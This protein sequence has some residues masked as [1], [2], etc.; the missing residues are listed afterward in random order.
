MTT[1]NSPVLSLDALIAHLREAVDRG[2]RVRAEELQR[3]ILQHLA[4]ESTHLEDVERAVRGLMSTFD[5]AAIEFAPVQTL[6]STRTRTLSLD[7]ELGGDAEASVFPVWFGTDR[8]PKLNGQGFTGERNRSLTCGRADVYIPK[9]HRPGEIGSSLLT[10]LFRLDLRDDSLRIQRIIGQTT[11]DFF[12]EISQVMRETRAAGTAAH[13]LFYLHGFNVGFDDAAI[14]A[15][16]L[17]KDLAV[18]GAT[19]F[20]SWPSKDSMFQ[21]TADEATIEAS[22]PAI[23]AFLVDFA[24]RC[25]ADKIHIIAHSMGNRG[26]LRALQ[27]IATNA[28]LRAKVR[29]GQIILAAPD[30]DQDVFADLAA[31]CQRQSEQT[32]LYASHQDLAVH[33]SYWKHAAPRAGYFLPYTLVGDIETVAVPDLDID[34][35]GHSYYA[36]AK[37]LLDDM[38]ERMLPSGKSREQRRLSALMFEGKRLWSLQAAD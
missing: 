31:M 10:R 21:Y 8:K 5:R 36:Q 14:R 26:L 17:G 30:V 27:R 19:A 4:A 1:P 2:D 37:P 18:P 13:A 28:E 3:A 15:A 9:T 33:A 11:D 25:G 23:T 32:T 24:A 34:R 16:Q 7:G 35:L 12:K 22:E 29:F 20:F 38:R 6:E